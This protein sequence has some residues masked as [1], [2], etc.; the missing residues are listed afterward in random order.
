MIHVD[1]IVFY[2]VHPYLYLAAKINALEGQVPSKTSAQAL[3][4]CYDNYGRQV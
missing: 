1:G 3:D 4:H 2:N